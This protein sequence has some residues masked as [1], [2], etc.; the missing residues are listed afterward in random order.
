MPVP[1]VNLVEFEHVVEVLDKVAGP[2]IVDRSLRAAGM[3]RKVLR[4]GP[5]YVP[6][7]I[8]AAFVEAVARA[9]G[10]RHLGVRLGL[11]FDY[12]AYRSYA[13]YIVGASSLAAAIA[14][15]RRAQSLI[16]PGSELVVRESGRHLVVGFKSGLRSVVGGQQ[17]DQAA[18]PILI[19]A[20]RHFLGPT[21]VPDWIEMTGGEQGH[22]SDFEDAIGTSIRSGAHIPAIAMRRSDLFVPN[23]TPPTPGD[24]VMLTDL[25][26]LLGVRQVLTAEDSVREALRTQFVLGDLSEGA[27][28]EQLLMGPRKMRRVLKAEGTSFREIR[29]QFLDERARL[30]LAET[31]LSIVE[32]ARTLGY[33]E[34]NNFRRAFRN[35]TG[36]SPREYRAAAILKTSMSE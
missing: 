25:P 33:S 32:I 34:P 30:L 5:G 7:A 18:I 17:I 14:R 23:P 3:R 11:A 36:L 15:G 9:L 27:V 10:E 1:M 21:W 13:R 19:S 4:A 29:E 24:A 35:W 20:A 28:S 8:E 2:Q 31:D 12:A 6:Y 22:V 26:V 16:H